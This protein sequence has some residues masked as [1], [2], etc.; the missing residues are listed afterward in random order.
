VAGLCRVHGI[1]ELT[2]YRWTAKFGGMELSE[3]QRLKALEE[4]R[5]SSKSS[6]SRPSTWPLTALTNT[7]R[8]PIRVFRDSNTWN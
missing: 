5:R 6:P 7:S 8:R 1:T 2:Y 4:N 3:M